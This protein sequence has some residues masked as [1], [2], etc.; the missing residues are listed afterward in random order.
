MKKIVI[1]IAL[2]LLAKVPFSSFAATAKVYGKGGV[3]VKPFPPQGVICPESATTVCAEVNFLTNI[4]GEPDNPNFVGLQVNLC[5]K[6]TRFY[7]LV[8]AEQPT[9]TRTPEGSYVFYSVSLNTDEATAN[10]LQSMGEPIPPNC[11]PE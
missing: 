8:V 2:L 4:P 7:N 6:N 3:V 5:Y 9:Y 10:Q 1:V 11:P